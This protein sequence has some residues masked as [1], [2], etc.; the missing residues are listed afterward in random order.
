MP[1]AAAARPTTQA[2]V[3]EPDAIAAPGRAR[4]RGEAGEAEGKEA[5]EPPRRPPLRRHGRSL[6]VEELVQRL[7]AL[8]LVLAVALAFLLL[9]ELV[10]ALV[11]GRLFGSV[12]A[13][14]RSMPRRRRLQSNGRNRGA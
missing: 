12:L 8:A 3:P 10:V 9:E 14:A 1:I 13:H 6:L 2:R 4:P 11:L 5:E 7:L